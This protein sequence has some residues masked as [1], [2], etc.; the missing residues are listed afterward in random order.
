M[1][2]LPARERL[3]GP[4]RAFAAFTKLVRRRGGR[5]ATTSWYLADPVVPPLRGWPVAPPGPRR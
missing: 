2:D 1:S 4:R 3:T 5:A